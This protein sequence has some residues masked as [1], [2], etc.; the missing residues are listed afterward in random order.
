MPLWVDAAQALGHVDTACGADVLYATS[1]KWL[2]GPRGVGLLAVS[3]RWWDTLQVR[4][5]PLAVKISDC[6][7]AEIAPGDLEHRAL[8]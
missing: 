5:S 1:R 6:L 4:T 3:D 8:R 7:A 2:T